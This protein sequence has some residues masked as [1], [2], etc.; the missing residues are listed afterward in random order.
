M[1]V[2]IK[3]DAKRQVPNA[4]IKFAR[5]GDVLL[6]SYDQEHAALITGF[7]EGSDIWVTIAES[8]FYPCKPSTRTIRL[9]DPTV[10]GI[11]RPLSTGVTS[12]P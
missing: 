12:T 2:N 7:Y 1:G 3:G 8:N 6:L 10:R 4:D 11:Y 5:A 9:N